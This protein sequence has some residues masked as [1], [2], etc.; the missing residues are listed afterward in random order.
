M[1]V[2]MYRML[3]YPTGGL[4]YRS[5]PTIVIHLYFLWY[6]VEAHHLLW[7]TW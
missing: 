3:C 7:R 2:C 1:L 6:P 5:P 4:C